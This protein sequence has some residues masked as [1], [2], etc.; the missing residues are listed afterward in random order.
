MEREKKSGKKREKEERKKK[1]IFYA[2]YFLR[3]FH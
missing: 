2:K 3:T 1:N